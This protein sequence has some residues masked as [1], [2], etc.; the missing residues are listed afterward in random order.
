LVTTTGMLFFMFAGV[1]S[2]WRSPE[3]IQCVQI[4]QANAE[5][6]SPAHRDGL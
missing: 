2:V 6:S 5:A 4:T 3:M 1:A